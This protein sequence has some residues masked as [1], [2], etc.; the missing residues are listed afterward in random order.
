MKCIQQK[1][2]VSIRD[3]L[4]AECLMVMEFQFSLSHLQFSL[5]SL[6]LKLQVKAL[7]W[8]NEYAQSI[9][10]YVFILGQEET[11]YGVDCETE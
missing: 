5:G 2:F 3:G 8:L 6:G 9:G 7:V 10:R 4:A 1:A 11:T